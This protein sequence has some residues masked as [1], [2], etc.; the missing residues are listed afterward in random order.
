M[1][2]AQEIDSNLLSTINFSS[3]RLI[4]WMNVLREENIRQQNSYRILENFWASQIR[5]KSWLINVLKMEFPDIS[6]NALILGGWY[7]LL[8]QMLVDNT[9]I[10]KVISVDI[11][12]ECKILGERLSEND[13]RIEFMHMDMKYFLN[14]EN[15]SLIL[16]T[17][18]EHMTQEKY[19]AWLEHIPNHIPIVLQG[20]NFVNCVDHV[21]CQNSLDHFNVESRLKRIVYTKSLDCVQF[22]RFMT[23]GY[24]N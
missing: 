13:P 14:F 6:G 9:N 11:D 16:N 5:S 8:A 20:N 22:H 24:K 19:D 18:T 15:I 1:S 3:T 4:Q 12:E 7:G 17:S 23:I 10:E 21:R 2:N